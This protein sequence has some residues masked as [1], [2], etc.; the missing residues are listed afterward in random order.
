MKKFHIST[1][2]KLLNV[3][4]QESKEKPS[5]NQ[6]EAESPD[7]IALVTAAYAYGFILKN[8]NPHTVLINNSNEGCNIEYELLKVLPFDS[9]S[10]CIDVY[11]CE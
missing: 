6:Y 9:N 10:K 11:K 7:E 5:T 1:K 3:N 2:T 4:K 8:R